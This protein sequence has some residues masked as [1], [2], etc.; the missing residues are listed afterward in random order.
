VIRSVV[1]ATG[2]LRSCWIIARAILQPQRGVTYEPNNEFVF[3]LMG[4]PIFPACLFSSPFHEAALQAELM[5]GVRT[6]DGAADALTSSNRSALCQRCCARRRNSQCRPLASPITTVPLAPIG[7]LQP[8]AHQVSP[9]APAEQIEQ[10]RLS[11][12]DASNRSLISRSTR[13]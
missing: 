8:R 12:F 5:Y 9:G 7:H 10:Q 2:A 1:D 4:M 13:V 11:T 3:N 6:I